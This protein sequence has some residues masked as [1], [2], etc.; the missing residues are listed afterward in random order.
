MSKPP[1]AAIINFFMPLLGDRRIYELWWF[2]E[3]FIRQKQ[4][5]CSFHRIHATSTRAQ[6]GA[7]KRLNFPGLGAVVPM[8]GC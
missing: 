4:L 7:G 1:F 3:M 5:E 6:S 2:D 8:D